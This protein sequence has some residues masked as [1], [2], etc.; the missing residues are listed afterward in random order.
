MPIHNWAAVS[1]GMFHWFHQTWIVRI[2]EWLNDGRLPEGFYAIGETYVD[3]YEPDVLAVEDRPR[4]LGPANGRSADGFGLAVTDAPPKTRFGWEAEIE[5]Y[6]AKQNL[7]AIRSIEGT[8]VGV[9][10]IVSAG[11]KSSQARFKKFVKKTV[12]F[13]DQGV[14]VLLIDLF[15]P[16]PRD[17]QGIHQAIWSS[18]YDGEF[19]FHPDKKLTLAAYRAPS[20]ETIPKAYVEPI[21][22]GDLLPEMPL[23]LWP[24]K[25][26]NVDLEANYADAWKVYPAPLK[27]KVEDAS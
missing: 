3:G 5:A 26:I 23:F 24:E 22:V 7:L 13:L 14:H 17:P 15:P 2:A 9:I 19:E 4:G 16:A 21:A 8:V 27:P 1:D 12:E 11:N 6:L 25:Y 20:V 18:Q 10:E